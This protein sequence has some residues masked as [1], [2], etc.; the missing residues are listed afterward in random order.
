MK[1]I[2]LMFLGML[3]M[4]ALLNA[5]SL[6]RL[7]AIKSG[8]AWDCQVVANHIF[9]ANRAA[10]AIIDI[11]DSTA[12]FI[13]Y[14]TSGSP[15]TWSLGLDISDTMIYVNSYSDLWIG[16][17]YPPDSIHFLVR[18]DLP[19]YGGIEPWGIEV[20]DTI[21]FFAD[22]SEGLYILN[23]SDPYN[24]SQITYYDTPGYLT[25]F[26]ILDT[27]IY[28]ADYDSMII[29]NISDPA[30][31]QRVGAVNIYREHTDVH[32]VW[33]YAYCTSYPNPF[34]GDN[35]SIQI[36]DVS[37]PSNPTVIGSFDGI[38][39]NTRAVFVNDEYV[40][41]ASTDWWYRS[42]K[43]AEGRADIEG[44][45]R[46]ASGIIPDSLI[47]SHDTP[48]EAIEIKV[49]G[50]L[51]LV[52]DHDS[53]MIYL[54]HKTGVAEEH[55]KSIPLISKFSVYPN[56][57]NEQVT[58]Y[59]QFQRATRVNVSVYDKAGRK[60]REIYHGPVL[61]GNAR[62]YW[63]GRDK[64]HNKIIPGEYFINISI[65]NYGISETKKAIFYGGCK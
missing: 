30:S 40:Y 21:L 22:G 38:R 20:V 47:I 2:T 58:C 54:H 57:F 24:P 56:P 27:L 33:P 4:S 62:L 50:D 32:V 42:N 61:A 5:D 13:T 51:V 63:D 14:E 15:I 23:V 25:E 65:K 48:G 8:S 36:V 53:L 16:R 59:L 35:G 11:S 44:G 9:L 19:E 55:F 3:I 39:G 17:L 52:P 7:S 28:C 49:R 41:V 64:N 6:E 45:I 29:L 60:V 43:E 1:K 46:I 18:Y 26:F 37:N 10:V 12:P 31:P 34:T